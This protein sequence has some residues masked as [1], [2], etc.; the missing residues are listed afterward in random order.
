MVK[1]IELNISAETTGIKSLKAELRETINALQQIPEGSAEFD[2]LAE[3]AADLKDRMAGVNEQV[4]ALASGSK[5]E[6]VTKAFGEMGAGLADLDFDR[7]VSGS[8]LFAKSAKAI[9]FKDA[10]GSVKS[11]GSALMTVGKAVLTN[12][13]FLL[14]GLIVAI[15][16]G[17]VKLMDKLGLLKKIFEFVGDAIDTVVQAIKDFLDYIGL[18]TFA[19][20]DQAAKMVDLQ[21]KIAAAYEEKQARVSKTFDQQIEIAKIEGKN[22][23]AME[24]QKQFAIIETARARYKALQEQLEQN[25]IS[26]TLDEEQIKEIQK[27]MK[28]TRESI[29]DARFEIKKIGVQEAEDNKAKN[30]QIAKDNAAAYKERLAKQKQYQ[31][32]RLA[33]TRAIQDAEL[34]LMHEGIDKELKANELKYQRLIEDTKKNEKLLAD[35]KAKTIELL[36]A[37]QQKKRSEIIMKQEDA[38]KAE[39]EAAKLEK[40]TKEREANASLL[41][42]QQE[43]GAQMLEQ[44]K[45]FYE[46]QKKEQEDLQN[47][48]YFMADGFIKGLQGLETLLAESGMKTAGLQKT[49]ALVQIA[50]DTAKAI[51]SVI[52]GATAA[53]AAGGPAAPFLIAG[54]IASGIGTVLSAVASAKKALTSAPALGGSSGGGSTPSISVPSGGGQQPSFNLYG[55]GNNANTVNAGQVSQQP[56]QIT[57][58][59]VV[60]ETEMTG[61]QNRVLQYQNAAQL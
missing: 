47:A 3:K 27:S 10:I 2:A 38:D 61:A 39:R 57:V 59:A 11:M 16:A 51:S 5:Y 6:K 15:A 60:S 29:G 54:Y 55:Q 32:D 31:E 30:E 4:N 49:I 12:P 44:Q 35:E 18:T 37:E 50:T 56:Q 20:E 52:A 1:N 23:V 43:A 48:R 41:E 46:K 28:A 53:A 33:A 17:I 13:L 22:T 21:G 45:A 19:A 8:N 9:T 7:L 58:Q 36:E 40:E 25:K 26:K 42:I 34:E 24:R 14:I